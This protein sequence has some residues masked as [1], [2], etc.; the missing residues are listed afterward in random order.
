MSSGAFHH[1]LATRYYVDT[2]GAIFSQVSM[3]HKISFVPVINLSVDAIKNLIG[4]GTMTDPY[5][6]LNET[7]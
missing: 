5:R 3:N 1:N 4:T 7:I 6:L 2:T